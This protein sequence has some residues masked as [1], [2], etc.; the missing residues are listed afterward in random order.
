MWRSAK[1]ATGLH[2]REPCQP[3]AGRLGSVARRA[4]AAALSA[5]IAL[6]CLPASLLAAPPPAPPITD[7]LQESYG[8]AEGLPQNTVR[9]LTHTADGYLWAAT[10]A[11]IARFDGVRFRGFEMRNSPGLTQDNIHVVAAARDGPLWVGTYTHGVVHF[12]DGAFTPVPGLSNPRINAILEDRDGGVW[13]ATNHGLNL[14]RSGKVSALTTADGLAGD[15]VLALAED[16]QGRLWAGTD[17]GL[18]LLD[19]GQVRPFAA[20]AE[21]A[22]ASV[23]SLAVTRGDSLWVAAKPMLLR[24]D[25]GMAAER[26]PAERLPTKEGITALAE[27]ASGAIWIATFGDGLF[28]LRAG[29]FERY[30]KEEGLPNSAIH[31]LL[32]ESDGSLWVGTNAAGM[33]R[34]RPRAIRQIGAPEGL[35]DTDAVA[36]REARDGS[37]WIATLGRGLNHYQ[38]GH[39]RTYTTRD[40]LSS[41]VVLGIGESKR[42]GAIWAGTMDGGL[43]WLEG[44]RFRHIQLAAGIQVEPIVEDPEGRLWVGTG[45]GLY[46]IENGAVVRLYTTADGLPNDSIF[47]ITESKDRSLWLGTTAGFSHFQRGKFTNYAAAK[48]GVPGVRILF[49]CEDSDGTLWLGTQGRGVGR[50]KNGRLAWFGIEEGLSDQVAYSVIDDGAGDLWI[51][52]NRGICRVAK[53]QL[54]QVAEGR[55]QRAAVRVYG[56]SDGLRSSECY[57]GTQPAGWRRRNGELVF[58]CIGG[59]VLID[60]GRLAGVAAPPRVRVEEARFDGRNVMPGTANLRIPPGGGNLEFRLYRHRFLRPAPDRFRYRLDNIDPNWVEADARRTAYYTKIPPGHYRFQVMAQNQDGVWSGALMSF[61]LAPHYYQTDLFHLG[62]WRSGLA[63]PPAS[64]AG[65]PESAANAR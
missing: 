57:G 10:Q 7:L 62:R 44:D 63:R 65:G 25:N 11:G 30:G 45:G 34:L 32:A 61:V 14:W 60:P 24:L 37:L 49:F 33:N 18:S 46:E 1:R 27:D 54:D 50:L 5:L 59:A 23:T 29:S 3:R 43:N 51:S 4:L 39:M 8:S 53:R 56:P 55:I 15:V 22:G 17:H 35:S 2:A 41:N 42:T 19:H 28:R 52:T 40:G 64:S 20:S 48:P 26:Y 31:C 47:A 12:R 38:D 16:R 6:L 9:S 36:V 13:I 21:L 58:A